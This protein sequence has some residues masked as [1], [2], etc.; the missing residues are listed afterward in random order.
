MLQSRRLAALA[1]LLSA[2]TAALAEG[3][4]CY[5]DP[6][7]ACAASKPLN[8]G[9][10]RAEVIAA[11]NAPGYVEP[12]STLTRAEVLAEFYRVRDR[13]ELSLFDED[14]GATWLALQRARGA[15]PTR[16][17]AVRLLAAR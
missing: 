1:V 9:R 6:D 13:G 11:I 16:L 12:V 7:T 17:A 4:L 3:P 10:T 8:S 2:A 15:A 5:P 14:S